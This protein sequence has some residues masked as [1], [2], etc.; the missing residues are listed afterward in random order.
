MVQAYKLSFLRGNL[1][2]GILSPTKSK[3][4]QLATYQNVKQQ[5][6]NLEEAKNCIKTYV[7]NRIKA[8]SKGNNVHET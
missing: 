3:R 5:S 8:N 6:Q 4:T 1:L 2:R 7:Q